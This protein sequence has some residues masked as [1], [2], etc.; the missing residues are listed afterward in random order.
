V[1]D[2]QRQSLE[3]REERSSAVVVAVRAAL[4]Q[5]RLVFAFQP[6]VCAATGKVD[7]FECL[8]RMRDE[9]G[10]IAAGC[11]FITI[12]EEVGLIG[13]IDGYVLQKAVDELAIDPHVR[14]GFNVSGL[15]T[16][17]RSWLR[18]SISLLRNRPELARR[19]VVEIT[20]TAALCNLEEAARF[21]ET[22]R[23]TGCRVALDDFGAGHT[24]LRHLQI[25]AVDTVKIDGSLIRNFA[26]SDENRS[27]LRRLV[28]LA[29]DF[30]LNT[31]AECVES[32]EEAAT[33]R[34]EGIGYLQGYHFG[35]PTIQRSWLPSSAA[36]E[37][38]LP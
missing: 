21:V 24:S 17:D 22:L 27:Y 23:H 16:A 38:V 34:K 33:L 12:I 14:L 36:G 3:D 29:K 13:L 19:L 18:S 25:L 37:R 31:V 4:R 35:R 30:G 20:E 32:A 26:I 15:T 8:L 1:D 11:E 28:G 2:L 9:A 10:R 6:V 5:D 7:Y